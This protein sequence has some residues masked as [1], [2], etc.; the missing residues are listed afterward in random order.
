MIYALLRIC[1][2]GTW[3]Q[4]PGIFSF[5]F[6]PVQRGVCFRGFAFC[7]MGK[8]LYFFFSSFFSTRFICFFTT[9]VLGYRI[10]KSFD[11]SGYRNFDISYGSIAVCPPFPGT[12]VLCVLMLNRK[13]KSRHTLMIQECW[14]RLSTSYRFSVVQDRYRYRTVWSSIIVSLYL[15]ITIII[16]S[17]LSTELFRL[18]IPHICGRNLSDSNSKW[19]VTENG[20]CSSTAV[21][22]SR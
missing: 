3:Y 2:T 8:S 1:P 6:S 22:G 4:V 5:S 19:V 21:A 18:I 7:V 11:V 16:Y 20:G 17:C 15:T 14:G 12:S 9:V 13:K 10:D